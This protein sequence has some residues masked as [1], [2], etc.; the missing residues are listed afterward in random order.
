MTT[1][2]F[3]GDFS[4][5]ASRGVHEPSTVRSRR[6]LQVDRDDLEDRLAGLGVEV[7]LGSGET[8]RVRE[9]EDMEPDRL[10]GALPS[11]DELR[12][13]RRRLQNP[14]TFREAAAELET[15]ATREEPA[16]HPQGVEEVPDGIAIPEDLL[17]AAM[18]ATETRAGAS[19]ANDGRAF[20]E[21]LAREVVAPFMEP[22]ADPRAP[23]LVASVDMAMSAHLRGVLQDPAFRYVEGAW[24]GL[25]R[26]VR[27]LET[28]PDLK[29]ELLDVSADELRSFVGSSAIPPLGNEGEGADP[30]LV[31][32][33]HRFGPSA[34]EAELFAALLGRVASTGGMLVADGSPGLIGAGEHRLDPD[35]DV[36]VDERDPEAQE[37][38]RAVAEGAAAAQGAIITNRVALRMPY[39]PH[40]AAVESFEFNEL[41][42][43][44][45]SDCPWGFGSMAVAHL[46][47]RMA[48]DLARR[49]DDLNARALI[50]RQPLILIEEAGEMVQVPTVE[51]ELGDRA[52]A[53]LARAGL[54]ALRCERG[55]D[56]VQVGPVIGLD[57]GVLRRR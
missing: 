17:S 43:G 52:V 56:H 46:Y 28:G 31:V 55:A 33:L 4:A 49:P 10:L 32:F 27:D 16:D 42:S 45:R 41:E 24:L 44:S 54:A 14:K 9:L 5:R 40:G 12:T 29:V 48:L 51:V 11:F 34:E 6:R 25:Q 1:I 53:K 50:D 7:R 47:G 26:V 20:A 35:P 15:S 36:W 8:V 21:N 23:E 38:W 22:K 3:V 37:R 2:L 39:G 13:L 19:S 57:G 18:E 30:D